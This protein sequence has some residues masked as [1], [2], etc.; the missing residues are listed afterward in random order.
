MGVLKFIIVQITV[1]IFCVFVVNAQGNPFNINTISKIKTDEKQFLSMI[2]NDHEKYLKSERIRKKKI[3]A[4]QE[5]ILRLEKI[6][7]EA[8]ERARKKREIYLAKKEQERIAREKEYARLREERIHREKEEEKRQELERRRVVAKIDVSKQRMMVYKG[9]KLLYKWKVSTGK[10]GYH[11]PRGEFKPTYMQRMHYSRKYNNSP[12]PYSVF[13]K[14]GY[15][16]HGTSHVWKLGRRASHGCIRLHT[17]N[18]KKFYHLIRQN[19]KS[20]TEIKIIN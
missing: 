20:N 16:V 18:A 14:G 10:N 9:G 19:G 3:Q 2:Y 13:F 5:E 4:E 12:M 7:Y 8:K 6:A 17:S 15:A 11:T 1:S